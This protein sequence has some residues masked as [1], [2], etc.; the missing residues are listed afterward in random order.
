MFLDPVLTWCKEN[1]TIAWPII[2]GVIV[3]IFKPRTPLQYAAL[4]AVYPRW[5]FARFAAL[6]QL[7]GALGVDPSKALKAAS[8]VITGKQNDG[9]KI[10]ALII[11][12]LGLTV[13]ACS[14]SS[15]VALKGSLYSTKLE[16]CSRVSATLCASIA[17]ENH[18][19]AIAGRFPRE[20]P[21][22]C[23]VTKDGGAE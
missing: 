3:T 21:G 6:L 17:C 15:D 16:E 19:R 5:F 11:L 7:I 2:S 8:K 14:P 9:S 20:V 12:C 13:N 1:P 4:S 10:I 18:E 23:K 22:Y